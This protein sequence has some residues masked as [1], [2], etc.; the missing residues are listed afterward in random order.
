SKTNTNDTG[1]SF[2]CIAQ[3]N[4]YATVAKRGSSTVPQTMISWTRAVAEQDAQS[5]CQ[6]ATNTLNNIVSSHGGSLEN[7]VFTVGSTSNG[8]GICLLDASSATGCN[9][10]NSILTLTGENA[11]NPRNALMSL[12]TYSVTGSGSPV[13][14]TAGIPYASLEGLD[15]N[16]QPDAG[17]WFASEDE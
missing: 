9:T 15:A 1:V 3:G 14:E 5:R 6:E 13:Q 17:L 8:I 10:S 12:L 4:G 7:L 16:L 2:S 11:R